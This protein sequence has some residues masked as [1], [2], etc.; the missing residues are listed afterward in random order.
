MMAYAT[1]LMPRTIPCNLDI[2]FTSVGPESD[3][4]SGERRIE[5]TIY[6]TEQYS[7]STVRLAIMLILGIY[8][9]LTSSPILGDSLSAVSR[10]KKQLSPV[11]RYIHTKLQENRRF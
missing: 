7:A 2:F 1:P 9:P 3:Q 5:S 4:G 11:L 10:A 8:E 6:T